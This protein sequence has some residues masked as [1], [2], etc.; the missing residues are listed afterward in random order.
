M[1]ALRSPYILICTFMILCGQAN[2]AWVASIRKDE[3]TDEKIGTVI[4]ESTKGAG[5]F[6]KQYSMVVRCRSEDMDEPEIYINWEQILRDGGDVSVRF[7]SDKSFSIYTS[8]STDNDATFVGGNDKVTLLHLMKKKNELRVKTEDFRGTD[9]QTGHFSLIGFN[10][11]Y[12]EACQWWEDARRAESDRI[13]KEKLRL[14][15]LRETRLKSYPEIEIRLTKQ[16][17]DA[18]TL[19][20]KVH[21]IASSYEITNE[22]DLLVIKS[23]L[24]Q[25]LPVDGKT[26]DSMGMFSR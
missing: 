20:E 9:T 5:L 8:I 25:G 16:L 19:D 17:E 4:S 12:S 13:A 21:L 18:L 22:F 11:A 24:E 6:G 23:R 14:E 26:L 15:T 7:D 2:A 1:S 10:A 3:M